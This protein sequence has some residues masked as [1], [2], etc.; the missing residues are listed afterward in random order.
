MALK[1]YG[2]KLKEQ[3]DEMKKQNPETADDFVDN[4][5]KLSRSLSQIRFALSL[6]C[7]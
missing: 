6:N 5:R 1:D 3:L 4:A 7:F 2:E